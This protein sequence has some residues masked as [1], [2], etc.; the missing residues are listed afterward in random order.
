MDFRTIGF[1]C[2]CG[3]VRQFPPSVLPEVVF[4]GRS[5]VG[6]SS[7]INRVADQKKLARISGTPGKTAT[8]NFFRGDSARLVD[9]PG[10]GYAKVGAA[11]RKRWAGLVGAFFRSGRDIRLVLALLDVRHPPTREDRAMFDFLIDGEL[12]FVAVLTKTD[13]LSGPQLERRL[14]EFREEVPCGD[15]VMF[16]P[17]S[18]VRNRGIGELRSVLS[19][20]IR[21]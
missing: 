14:R 4:A 8:I 11:E 7:L 19:D 17:V 21:D 15:Q 18:A 5:N 16:L 1:E 2:S 12:P 9:L 6:K 13:K 10:Y 3:F 20:V